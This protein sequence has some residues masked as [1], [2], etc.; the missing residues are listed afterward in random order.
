MQRVTT[1]P[2][3]LD[4]VLDEANLLPQ[5]GTRVLEG[6][7]QSTTPNGLSNSIQFRTLPLSDERR[8]EIPVI[9]THFR[10]HEMPVSY[11]CRQNE[12]LNSDIKTEQKKEG[13]REVFLPEVVILVCRCEKVNNFGFGSNYGLDWSPGRGGSIRRSGRRRAGGRAGCGRRH[14]QK[15]GWRA[16]GKRRARAIERARRGPRESSRT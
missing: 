10:R 11:E 1:P 15:S 4:A 13:V 6:H 16:G 8:D 12:R 14:V 5:R 3:W 2:C 7:R 9:H